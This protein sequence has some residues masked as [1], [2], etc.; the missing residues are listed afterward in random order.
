MLR[1]NQK[2]SVIACL[3]ALSPV[4][5]S[6]QVMTV[7]ERTLKQSEIARAKMDA[8][9]AEAKK[10][11]LGESS[12]PTAAAPK[13][14][15][16][17]ADDVLSLISVY[18]VGKNLKADFLFQ[19]AIITLEPGSKTKAAGWSVESLTPT[20]AVMV[21][22]IGKTVARRESVY[23]AA[24]QAA[25]PLGTPAPAPVVA[26]AAAAPVPAL[27]TATATTASV[28]TAAPGGNAMSISTTVNAPAPTT[29]TTG[30]PAAAAPSSPQAASANTATIK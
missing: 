26:P 13:I 1:A 15:E 21:K 8:D 24:A 29:P 30:Q 12:Q 18:G 23:L 4:L 22:Y 14:T 2:L 28:Q 27:P 11:A 5:S 25:A 7:T 10:R 16:K 9:L 19:G 3:L 20:Q 17:S 6:A